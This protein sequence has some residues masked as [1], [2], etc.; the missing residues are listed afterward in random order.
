MAY[1]FRVG[2]ETWDFRKI[3]KRTISR[4]WE[5][6]NIRKQTI[7]RTLDP[8]N[9]GSQAILGTLNPGNTGSLIISAPF[10]LQHLEKIY[11]G[12]LFPETW[13]L[14]SWNLAQ[15]KHFSENGSPGQTT[16]LTRR[17]SEFWVKP[18]SPFSEISHHDPEKIGKPPSIVSWP[19][20]Q[21]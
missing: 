16:M 10:W 19:E 8:G 3:G 17:A 20:C 11:F 18:R 1:W 13:T 15:N 5:L 14:E 7:L 6:Q 21:C 12:N 2:L 9:T 4:T